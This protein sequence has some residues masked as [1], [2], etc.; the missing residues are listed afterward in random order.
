MK[1]VFFLLPAAMFIMSLQFA[2]SQ[3]YKTAADTVK[4]NKEYESVSKDIAD[5]TEELTNAQNDLPV[6]QAKVNSANASAQE[7]AQESSQQAAKASNGDLDDIKKAK[8]KANKA[9]DNAEDA[10]DAQNKV[11]DLNKKIKKLNSKLE[12]KQKK[13]QELEAMRTTIRAMQ[14]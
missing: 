3:K 1:K 5:L 8:K 10:K 9:L 14:S 4:L 6:Y 13:L 7:S 11:K 12:K 2:F